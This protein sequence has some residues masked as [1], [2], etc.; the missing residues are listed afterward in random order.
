MNLLI[1]IM[2]NQGPLGFHGGDSRAIALLLY[3]AARQGN[4]DT[5][6]VGRKTICRD[7]GWDPQRRSRFDA[8]VEELEDRKLLKVTTSLI[9]NTKTI[10]PHYDCRPT[11]E[12][13]KGLDLPKQEEE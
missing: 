4:H 9:P 3:L 6:W 8:V 12:V 5:T 7:L 1:Q 2:L 11:L 13:L 10:A